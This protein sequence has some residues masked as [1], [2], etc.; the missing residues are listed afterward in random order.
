MS[1]LEF[2]IIE[3]SNHYNLGLLT[4][5]ERSYLMEMV[6]DTVNKLNIKTEMTT[7]LAIFKNKEIRKTIHNNE[8]WFC[9]GDVVGINWF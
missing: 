7:K 4:T 3:D 1:W 9:I 6:L 5:Q 8:W 2:L